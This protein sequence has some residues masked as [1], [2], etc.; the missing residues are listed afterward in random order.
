MGERNGVVSFFVYD[1]GEPDYTRAVYTPNI[2][3]LNKVLQEWSKAGIRFCGMV[4]SH[5]K[6]QSSLSSGDIGYINK[7]MEAMPINVDK[8]YFPLVLSD[9]GLVSFIAQKGKGCV[10]ILSDS[11]EVITWDEENK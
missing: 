6:G 8:L 7:I 9:V 11:L 5:P 10:E 2:Q 4:H 3:Q 1:M